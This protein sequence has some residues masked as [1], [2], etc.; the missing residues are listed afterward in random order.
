VHGTPEIKLTG[1]QGVF[2]ETNMREYDEIQGSEHAGIMSSFERQIGP[3]AWK[4][5][6]Q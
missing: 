6:E 5:I 1:T 2:V 3:R 4:H